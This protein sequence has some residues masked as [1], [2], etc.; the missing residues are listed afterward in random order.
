MKAPDPVPVV[1]S[2]N[3]FYTRLIGLLDSRYLGSPYSLTQVRVLFEIAHMKECT[4]RKIVERLGM[5]EGYMSRIV[6]GFCKDGLICKTPSG[7]DRRRHIIRLTP[8]GTKV[9]KDLDARAAD[10]IRRI[11]DPLSA[12]D[13]AR[14]A[15]ALVRIEKLLSPALA[16]E[17][18]NGKTDA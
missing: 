16:M 17:E 10:S 3:R 9:F 6:D 12:E 4:A 15:A 1:R 7:Q 5:D 18:D 14:L 8:M 13:K 2:F 11:V